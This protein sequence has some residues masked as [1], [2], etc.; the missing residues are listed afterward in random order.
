MTSVRLPSDIEEKLQMLS[1]SRHKSK[2]D[3]I[4]E[5]LELLLKTETE[6]KDSYEL[7]KE[8]FGRFGSGESSGDYKSRVKAKI[9]AKH[10]PN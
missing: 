3:I 9:R 2:S 6:E 5:A 8:L 1:I 10:D 4:K 7:G